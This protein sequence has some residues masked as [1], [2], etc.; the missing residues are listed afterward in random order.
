MRALLVLNTLRQPRFTRLVQLRL[1]LGMIECVPSHSPER[2]SPLC[3]KIT[4]ITECSRATIIL[5]LVG[6]RL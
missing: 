5:C 6:D 3:V 2:I 1:S 4:L